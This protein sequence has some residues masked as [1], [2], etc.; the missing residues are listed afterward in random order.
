MIKTSA[1]VGVLGLCAFASTAR[2]NPRPLPFSYPYET[3]L[4]GKVEV[5]Q[6]VDFIPVRVERESSG[7]TLENVWGVRSVLATEAALGLTD[8]LELAFSC[9][10]RQGASGTTPFVRFDG[11]KQR[12]RYRFAETGELPIDISL[13]VAIAELQNK[14]AF[15]E[16]LLLSKRFGNIVFVANLSVEQEW[17][18]QDKATTY[19]YNPTAGVAYEITPRYHVGLEYWARGRFDDTSD[20]PMT[21][22]GD[23]TPTTTH[24]YLGPTF[25]YQQGSIFLSLGVYARLDDFGDSAIGDPHGKIWLRSILGLEL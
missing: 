7:G 2:A 3:L 6:H 15:D 23:D 24:Q 18:F 10:F 13:S 21:S 22:T 16:K 19:I 14:L 8:R 4:E 9:P 11:V 25:L 17:Y 5:E 12:L 20:D 1:L